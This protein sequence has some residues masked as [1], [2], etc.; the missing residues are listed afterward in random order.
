[1]NGKSLKS[2]GNYSTNPEIERFFLGR[3]REFCNNQMAANR[4]LK[5]YA[6]PSTTEPPGFIVH[7]ANEANNLKLK[8]ALLSKVHGNQFFWFMMIRIFIFKFSC[9]IVAL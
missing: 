8:Q 5:E 2:R 9:N 1:L 3:R 7:L 4:T 6:T